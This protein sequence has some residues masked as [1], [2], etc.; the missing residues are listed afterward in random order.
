MHGTQ[1]KMNLKNRQNLSLLSS[2]VSIGDIAGKGQRRFGL[3]HTC[4][5][6]S[7]WCKLGVWEIQRKKKHRE[8]SLLVCY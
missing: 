3:A 7:I 1:N 2:Q 6:R 8:K 4:T 5:G